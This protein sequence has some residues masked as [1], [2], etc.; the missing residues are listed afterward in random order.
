MTAAILLK[1]LI[2]GFAIAAPVGPVGVIAFGVRWLR[3]AGT[4]LFPAWER[5]QPMRFTGV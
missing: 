5:R 2:I 3:E 4:D 1:G